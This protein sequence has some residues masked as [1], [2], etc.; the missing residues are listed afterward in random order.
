MLWC[1]KFRY[2]KHLKEY[3]HSIDSQGAGRSN[4]SLYLIMIWGETFILFF[5]LMICLLLSKV[6]VFVRKFFFRSIC[7]LFIYLFWRIVLFFLFFRLINGIPRRKKSGSLTPTCVIHWKKLERNAT[8]NKEL[9]ILQLRH[10]NEVM[11]QKRPHRQAQR[12]LALRQ[13]Q[14]LS[15]ASRRNRTP[16]LRMERFFKTH[17]NFRT[18]R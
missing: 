7:L 15:C 17:S 13:R 1:K 8:A 11:R 14:T 5:F 12:H 6:F 9:H 18:L 10:L 16:R 2:L 3:P 4:F